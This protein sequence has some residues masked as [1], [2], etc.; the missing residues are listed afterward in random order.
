MALAIGISIYFAGC[1][2]IAKGTRQLITINCNVKDAIIRLDGFKIGV[3][4]FI[5]E[6][7][8]NGQ[9]LTISKEG[10]KTHRIALSK[11][12]EAAFFGNIITGGTIGSITD[13][14]TG[15]AYQYSPA[16][17]Q[18]DLVAE[19]A[20]LERFQEQFEL[21]KFAMLNMSNIVID[22]SN[23][24]GNYLETIVYL[25][26]LNYDEKSKELIRNKII[27]SEGDQVKFGNLIVDILNVNS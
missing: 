12:L 26:K 13:F 20:S 18:V 21:R 10:Y 22:I 11:S 7:K 17:Y 14:A 1:A 9:V 15:A 5:G 3:T 25:A 6:V 4:P 19:T 27:E 2:T 16:S 23:N 8:K 24:S